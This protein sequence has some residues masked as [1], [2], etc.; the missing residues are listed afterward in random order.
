MNEFEILIRTWKTLLNSFFEDRFTLMPKP[1]KD[2]AGKITDR[3]LLITMVQ[4]FS[5]KY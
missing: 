1:E 4:K 3:Y 5:T 2:R